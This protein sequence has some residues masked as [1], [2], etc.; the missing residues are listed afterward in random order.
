MTT[1][2]TARR[3]RLGAIGA[4]ITVCLPLASCARATDPPATR[5]VQPG[6]PIPAPGAPVV[7]HWGSFFGAR[8]GNFD[9]RFSPAS[10]RL[11]GPVRQVGTSNSTQYALLANGTLYAWGLGGQGQLGDGGTTDSFVRPV[12]VVFPPGVKIAWIPTD[13]MPYDT[14]LA[15]DT[16]GHAWGWGRNGYGQLCTGRAVRYLRPV[17][18]PLARVTALAGASNHLIFASQ[19]TVYACG[20]NVAG[21][22][23]TGSHRT[24][25]RPEPVRG[26]SHVTVRALTAS[27]A[28][29]GALLTNGRYLDWGYNGAG[30]LGGGLK[31]RSS[32]VPVVVRLPLAARQVALGGSIWDNGQSLA[33]LSDGSVWAWGS[34]AHCQLGDG[35]TRPRRSP[36]RIGPPAGVHYQHL[37]SGS[38][39]SY[40]VTSDGKVYA[41][42]VSH[43]GQLGDG[44]SATL[45]A[46]VLVGS[47]AAGISA[48]ANN[49][50]I[51]QAAG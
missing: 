42:G 46:P 13:V 40:A 33:L 20:Q 41:W 50:V 14:G 34:N 49:V 43:V 37:A 32:D 9:L 26:L 6:L 2:L 36:V 1:L 21:D 30:Q 48:T 10:I 18:L 4:A 3:W 47:R 23:G 17:R 22:L 15:V 19:G 29:S 28:N 11:P 44:L 5:P 45:C 16:T 39:T 8:H 25:T 31:A 38:A 12:R 7:R 24:T 35:A 51:K 27:F